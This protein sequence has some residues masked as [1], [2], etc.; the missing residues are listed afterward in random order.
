MSD[1]PLL[2]PKEVVIDLPDGKTKSYVISKF[3]A[4]QGREIVHQWNTSSLPKIGDYQLNQELFFKMMRHV[5]VPIKGSQPMRLQTQELINNHVDSWITAD[6]LEK[7][8]MEYNYYFFSEEK[9]SDSW[10]RWL[11][12]FP[13]K[14][15]KILTDS[16]AQSLIA[17]RQRSTN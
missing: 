16:L 17:V 4:V 10:N 12:N 11:A 7:E 5:A 15:I 9:A 1:Y 2:E 13:V 8:M 6:K 3:P 14:I